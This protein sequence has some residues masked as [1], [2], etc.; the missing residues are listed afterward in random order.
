MAHF[1]RAPSADLAPT[2]LISP[3]RW[4]RQTGPMEQHIEE[5]GPWTP[6]ISSEMPAEMRPLVTLLRPENTRTPI[7]TVLEL[8]K[9]TALPPWESWSRYV[10][11][12]SC[13][14]SSWSA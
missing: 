8:Q 1:A 9:L 10:L 14:T 6:G 11:K 5:S 13:C 2:D 12:D 3:A 4:V 7:A